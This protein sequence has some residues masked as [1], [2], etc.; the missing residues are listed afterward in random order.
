MSPACRFLGLV[1]GTGRRKLCITLA[2][3]ALAFVAGSA[4]PLAAA[5]APSPRSGGDLLQELRSFRELG[6]VLYVAAHPDDENTR[7]IA[8]LAHHRGVATAYLSLTRGD[9][10]QNLLGPELGEELGVIRTQELLA[11]RRLDGARQYFTRAVDFGFSKSSEETLALW[12]RQQ[13]LADMV[14][15]IRTFRPDVMV[16]RFA[17]PASGG[18]GHGQHTASAVLALE[19]FA[20]A[21]DGAAFRDELAGLAP[22]QPKRIVWNGYNFGGSTPP[23]PGTPGVFTLEV[24]G[25]D[26]LSGESP[27][28]IAA[29]SR[30][31]HRSQGMGS[32]GSRGA[33]SEWFQHLAGEPATAGLLDG[34]DTTWNRIPGGAEVACLAEQAFD[35]FDARRPAAS[36]PLLLEIRLRLAGISLDP[37]VAEKRS[38]LDRILA[39]C[40]GLYWETVVDRAEVVPGESLKLRHEV[41]AR[42]GVPVRWVAVR[43]PVVNTEEAVGLDLQ[44]NQPTRR[45]LAP[46]LP[47]GTAPSQPYWLRRPG[48]PGMFA[49][50]EPA[51]IGTA[52]DPPVF[53]VE[54][55]F[56][57]GGQ[58]L[59]L[60]DEPVQ[61]LRDPLRGEIRRPLIAIP[62]VSLAYGDALALLAP[63]A[64]REVVVEVTAARAAAGELRLE[65][66]AGWTVAPAS[67]AFKL[68]QPEAKAP[69]VFAVTAPNRPATAAIVAVAAVEGRDYRSGRRTISYD[70]L[71][72]LLLQPV[73]R[74]KA[75]SFELAVR[76]RKVGYLSGAGDEIA[77][78]LVRMGCA[79]TALAEPDLTAERLREFDA[80]VLG[81]RA[82]NTRAGLTPQLPNLAAYVEQGGTVVALYNRPEGGRTIEVAPF[83]VKV[84]GERVTDENAVVTLLA[85]EHPAL[86]G[87][88]RI[89][90]A[91]FENWV[92]ERGAYF[93]NQWDERFVALLACGDPGEA[94]KT[95]GLLVAAHGRGHYVYTSLAFFRQLPDGVP[96]AYRLFGNLLSLS[97]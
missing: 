60:A 34:V 87:P 70:H 9:G 38:Q 18:G 61:V 44:A 48:T 27:G 43:Y 57:V 67:Q 5:T 69:L 80:V 25:Y 64:T 52:E 86:L 65:V 74:L 19:A 33:S 13:V 4:V 88:N 84:S 17:L 45:E 6:R 53:P 92:Q 59:V 83:P 1:R 85:P 72:P 21:G 3:A 95:G 41:I 2:V 71:P 96:G 30:T 22:W 62:P 89:V 36:V 14:R 90:A 12:D 82:F 66:P 26:P 7:L 20:L 94:A 35:Q 78:C 50:E 81:V 54:Q 28:E 77:A 11:A 24:G 40:L 39:A 32:I 37:V 16:S 8:H 79:V 55:V 31:M 68:G 15:V 46:V 56:E 75:V 42:A 29:L 93:P 23:A 73:A 97:K 63:G 76:A 49:V 58:R 51:L 47:A 10:G 91:D